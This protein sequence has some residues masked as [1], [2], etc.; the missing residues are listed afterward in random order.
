[1]NQ[2]I[3]YVNLGEMIFIQTS[4]FR[5]LVNTNLMNKAFISLLT[6]SLLWHK[7]GKFVSKYIVEY[8]EDYNYKF[9]RIENLNSN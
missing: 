6:A 5:C 8:N 7:L 2:V 4:I 1:M 9:K 3:Q